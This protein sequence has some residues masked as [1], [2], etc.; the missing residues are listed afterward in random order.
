MARRCIW[1]SAGWI[2]MR[3]KALLMSILGSREPGPRVRILLM[4]SSMV[5]YDIEH[6]GSFMLC[7]CG[8]DRSTI[9]RHFPGWWDLGSRWMDS[10]E[11]VARVLFWRDLLLL[12]WSLLSQVLL[13]DVGVFFGRGHVFLCRA[14]MGHCIVKTYLKTL[15]DSL[16]KNSISAGDGWLLRRYDRVAGTRGVT[17]L[18]AIFG[19]CI[20]EPTVL[21]MWATQLESQD[22]CVWSSL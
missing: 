17:M 22:V 2:G 12:L 21:L 1:R 14:K 19:T 11:H 7:V 13:H 18:Q 8:K 16:H 10:H 15:W 20:G 6:M 5:T 3:R 4:A 9:S